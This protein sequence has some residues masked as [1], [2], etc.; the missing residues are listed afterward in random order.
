LIQKET[1]FTKIYDTARENDR[2]YLDTP[3]SIFIDFIKSNNLQLVNQELALL[4]SQF[5][6]C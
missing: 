6:N 5:M 4:Y 1:Y 3:F 2:Q